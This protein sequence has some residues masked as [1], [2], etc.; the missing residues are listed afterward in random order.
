MLALSRPFCDR[1]KAG[2][3]HATVVIFHGRDFCAKAII[4]RR[5]VDLGRS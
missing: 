2:A 5:I 3:G 4:V 1:S